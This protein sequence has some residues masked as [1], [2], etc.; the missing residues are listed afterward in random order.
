MGIYGPSGSGKTT[1]LHLLAGLQNL[2]GAAV[3][4]KRV[5]HDGRLDQID[6]MQLNPAARDAWRLQ[7]AG[8]VFQQFQL[9]SSMTALENVVTPLRLDHWRL[10]S[11]ARQRALGLLDG[12]S[13]SPS[14]T[15]GL[16]S[17][18]EQQRVAIARAL[19]RQPEV[20]LADEPTASLD[21]ISAHHVIDV[22]TSQCASRGVTL[23]VATHDLTMVPK[24]DTAFTLRD[25]QLVSLKPEIA[26]SSETLA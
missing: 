11:D 13:I 2:K 22:L 23:V 9:F 3:C 5:A 10:P 24:F 7:S 15:A 21:P 4:W 12:F 1:L 19:I 25:G 17:R 18:G 20:L 6:L 16:L 14:A 26:A 8:L